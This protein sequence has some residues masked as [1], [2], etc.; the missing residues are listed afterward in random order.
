MNKAV[1]LFF[2]CFHATCFLSAQQPSREPPGMELSGAISGELVDSITRR[3][4][5][6]AS[7]GVFNASTGQVING[8]ITDSRGL[9]RIGELPT[10]SYYLQISFVGYTTKTVR[11]ISLTANKPDANIGTVRLSPEPKLLEAVEVVGEAA[12]IEARPDKIV[13]N[14]EQDVTSRGGDA[15]DVLRKVPLLAVDLDGNVSMRGS[16]NVRV[17]INGRPSSIFNN[18]L[19][20]ALKMMPADQIKSV[21]VITSPSAKY[22]GEGTAGIINIVTRKKNVQGLAGSVDLTGGTRHHRGNANVSYGKGRLGINFSGGGH[23]SPAQDGTY[24]SVRTEQTPFGENVLSQDGSSSSSRLGYRSN[25]G[26]K[27]NI[28]ALNSISSSFQVRG[29]DSESDNNVDALYATNDV[30]FEDYNRTV[31]SASNRNGWD[32][33]FEYERRFE[34]DDQEFSMALE[35]DRD[36]NESA[37]EYCQT[38]SLPFNTADL[39]ELNLNEGNNI[40]IVGEMD[41]A[42]PFSEHVL[43]EI[44]GRA[45]L[46][47][48]ESVFAF[49]RYDPDLALWIEDPERTDIF[50]YD[51]HVYAGYVSGTI[52][53]G[54]RSTFIT[55]LRFERTVIEGTFD[56]FEGDFDNSYN[57]LLPNLTFSHRLGEYN[58]VKVSYNQRIQR[59]NQ[60]HINPFVEYSDNRDVSFGNPY[61]SP[62]LVHQVELGTNIFMKGNMISVSLFGRHTDDLIENL[63]SINESGVSE[64][65]YEN[66]GTRNAV[67]L[68]VFGTLTLGKLSLRGGFDVN[69]W[70]VEGMYENEALDNSGYDYNG[71]INAT[72][73]VSKTL[74][75]EGFAFFRSPTYTVQGKTPNWSTMSFGIR[76]EMLNKRLSLGINITEPFRENLPWER[77]VT[78][79]DFY[80]YSKTLRPVR[81]IGISLGYRFG[82]L[83][84]KEQHNKQKQQNNDLKDDDQG[85]NQFGGNG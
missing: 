44:G 30:I 59:P 72:W 82:K 49:N 13:Y 41:Y 67:G 32:Y 28:N 76:K 50:F 64:S 36:F 37:S 1:L 55:G 20:D 79:S 51:Q 47:D 9:F 74:K 68:N 85:D 81:S 63:V 60:R 48:I 62:E 29:H 25:L 54:E 56:Q 57:N 84:F 70:D 22:D 19:A 65:T 18:N 40:E 23:Y 69:A 38:Y 75:M 73:E 26:L 33:E 52:K 35:I 34:A 66:F 46:R 6:F 2:T 61:L 58:Q 43:M 39:E 15:S 53:L 27:Y 7:V 78:G 83:D 14:A 24:E 8:T 77:E 5:E 11:N 12:L 71:R 31:A 10:G 42:H 45:T 4:L 3:T 80:Q 21:E 17:L 16:D